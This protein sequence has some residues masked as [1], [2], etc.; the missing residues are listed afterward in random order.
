MPAARCPKRKSW[1]TTISRTC[2][3]ST[4][5]RWTNS[6]GSIADMASSKCRTSTASAPAAMQQLDA[7]RHRGQRRRRVPWAHD[8]RGMR[9]ERD[10]HQ[11]HA[12]GV[13][14]M[15]RDVDERLV[16]AVDAVEDADAGD[17]A[18]RSACTGHA[19]PRCPSRA[20]PRRTRRSSE[21]PRRRRSPAPGTA[22]P[23][24][25]APIGP[26]A[27]A[28]PAHGIRRPTRAAS[29]P[30]A[31]SR[32]TREAGGGD[33]VDPQQGARPA[34]ARS[35]RA[36]ARSTRSNGPTRVRRR[37]VRCPPTPRS[38]PRSRAS[39]RM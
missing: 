10:R 38:S 28:G 7:V 34:L 37:L 36:T 1:P 15:T 13:G 24:P 2:S 16:S 4:S 14:A 29:A 30:S 20:N 35:R 31:S 32:Q 3:R 21:R 5:T 27:L 17:A 26:S 25:R 12:Q 6:C 11:G 8:R 18:A 33:L 22:R 23:G 19:G 39:A 9:V